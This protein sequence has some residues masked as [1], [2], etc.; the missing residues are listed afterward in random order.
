[1]DKNF[2]S[3]SAVTNKE[4]L[5]GISNIC[6]E[7][8]ITFPIVIGYQV[9]Y[10]SINK[11]IQGKRQPAFNDLGDLDKRTVDNGFITAIHYHTQDNETLI[12]DL[13]KVIE[14]GIN[15]SK[16]LLQLNALL[17]TIEILKKIKEMGYKTIFKVAVSDKKSRQGKYSIWGR[18]GVEDISYGNSGSLISQ[19][20]SRKNFIKYAMF[21]PSHGTNLDLDLSEDSLAI[22]FGREIINSPEFENIGL[23]YA[24]GINPVNV[25]QLTGLL[26]KHFPN[27]FSIDTESGVRTNN[28]LDLELIKDYLKGYRDFRRN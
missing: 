18:D 5:E 24:G 19:V 9:S 3:I 8:E 20:H 15:P 26:H 6:N 27:R 11:K 16:T 12:S 4:Q 13:E 10:N 2:V 23:V 17:P 7:E 28:Q 22:R 21:D 1:M 14:Q 25:K